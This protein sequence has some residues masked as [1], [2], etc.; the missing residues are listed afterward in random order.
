MPG[1]I[2]WD[3][4]LETGIQVID[5]QHKEF[6]RLVNVLLDTSIKGADKESVLKAFKF[7]HF[8]IIEH[9]GMEESLM[10]EYKYLS[11]K[12]HRT[13]HRY[14]K[15]ELRKLEAQLSGAHFPEVSM[16]LDYLVVNWFIN[17]IKVQDKKLAK[18]LQEKAKNN[19][20]IASKLAYLLK[21]LFGR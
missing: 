7:L 15:D 19:R 10:M 8:Y 17:H 9:F 2:E 20:K 5:Q 3:D 13:G 1:K 21:K 11:L 4:D 6:F 12:E 14:F 16:R 18:F